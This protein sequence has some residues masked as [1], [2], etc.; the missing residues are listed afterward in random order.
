MFGPLTKWVAQIDRAD[1]VPEYVARAF[2]TAT[3]GRPGP[4]VLALP[5]DMLDATAVVADALP[6][7]A[8]QAWPSGADLARL[9]RI[10]DA[11]ERPMVIA[12]GPGWNA[13]SCADLQVFAEAYALPV[14][15]AFRF[16]DVFDNRHAHYIGDVGIGINPALAA[17]IRASDCVIAFGPRLGEMT[18]SG[19][20][21]L[22]PPVPT[23]PL[24][25]IHPDPEE[26]GR[27]YQATLPILAG[28]ARDRGR[29]AHRAVDAGRRRAS[30]PPRVDRR[31]AARVRG[32]AGRARPV[33][34]S[35]GRDQPLAGGAAAR[36]APAGRLR[37]R[38]R[39]PAISRRGV[40][41]STAI[42]ASARSSR[43]P[44]GRWATACRPASP[45]RSSTP[46]R[47]VV[48]LAGDGDFL[49]TG[50]ELATAVREQAGVL[51]IVVDN[52]MYGTIRM[53]QRKNFPGRVSGTGL[54]NPDFAALAASY[55]ALGIN[56]VTTAAFEVALERALTFIAHT[57]LPALI[58]LAADPKI[59]TPSMVLDD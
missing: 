57:A 35:A 37:P 54:T 34:R 11:A 31:G 4:V 10:V 21:L 44:R 33:R 18:T 16:Q 58:A 20:T 1:R 19:Y 5:E 22:T 47:A 53:H 26:H 46:S 15:C 29:V 36:P 59:I 30:T 38:Q 23:Q 43:R 27:V 6:Y 14:A 45:R 12:G 42:R 7:R 9:K 50:Q 51:F 2:A 41:A 56:V 55:G 39:P 48:V 28:V 32:L 8:L 13:E 3:S 49:M 17:Y 52:G 25:H 24:I 40:I